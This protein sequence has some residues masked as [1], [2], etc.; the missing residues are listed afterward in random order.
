M[1]YSRDSMAFFYHNSTV[2][3]KIKD[4]FILNLPGNPLASSLIFE[5]FGKIVVQKLNGDNKIY[6]NTIK[7]K[8]S[9]DLK[10]KK[11]RCT[12]IAGFFDGE[13]FHPSQKMSSGMINILNNC[14]SMIVLNKD[15]EYLKQDDIVRCLPINWKFFTDTKKE[16]LTF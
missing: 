7:T 8:I 5:L 1:I 15:I 6:H 10:N 4:T 14:N 11:G 9:K 12:I 2:F 13:F 16:F 3:G